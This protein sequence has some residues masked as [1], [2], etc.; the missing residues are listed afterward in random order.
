MGALSILHRWSKAIL[1]VSLLL[2]G[3]LAASAAPLAVGAR[4]SDFQFVDVDEVARSTRSLRDKIWVVSVSDK[5][6]AERLQEWIGAASLKL[7]RRAP[8]LPVA[9]FNIADVTVVP[10]LF[11]SFV[12]GLM[13]RAQRSGDERMR[14]RLNKA[15]L[16]EGSLFRWMY[17]IPDWEGD[18]LTR[19]GV[20]NGE[21]FHC[22]VVYRG[23]VIAS[24]REGTPAIEERYL[25]ALDQ[26][27]RRLGAQGA[28]GADLRGRAHARASSAPHR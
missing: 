11:H 4:L 9:Y 3:G 17:L 6:S 5:D 15:S 25:S 19:L 24:L 26:V 20:E 12:R 27:R 13:R 14:E 7:Q 28:A 1:F 16:P 10:G 21:Q 2:G 22:W 8:E 18:Y 23:R